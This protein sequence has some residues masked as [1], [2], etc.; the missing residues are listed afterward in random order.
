MN[1]IELNISSKNDYPSVKI[2]GIALMQKKNFDIFT[3]QAVNQLLS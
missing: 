3:D 2:L 1:G